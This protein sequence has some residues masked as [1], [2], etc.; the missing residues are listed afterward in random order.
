MHIRFKSKRLSIYNFYNRIIIHCPKCQKKAF[1]EKVD[2]KSNNLFSMEIL[3]CNYCGYNKKGTLIFDNKSFNLWLKTECDGKELWAFNEEHLKYL[4]EYVQ[5]K[6]RERKKD[7]KL[8]WSNKSLESRLPN[9]IRSTKNREKVLKG[10]EKL[11][12]MLVVEK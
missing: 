6:L 8:G 1:I 2:K 5:A 3:Y 7:E 4:K 11:E 12:K 10:I 9:W